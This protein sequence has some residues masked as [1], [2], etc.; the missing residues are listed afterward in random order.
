MV[1]Q[2][3]LPITQ[4]Q[5]AAQR[6][7]AYNLTLRPPRNKFLFKFDDKT[8]PLQ[9]GFFI[10]P[11]ETHRRKPMDERKSHTKNR[12]FFSRCGQTLKLFETR[13]A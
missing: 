3:L 5:Q 13:Q 10:L 12:R 7:A 11:G 8:P 1:L 6:T 9:A 4:Q 2:I